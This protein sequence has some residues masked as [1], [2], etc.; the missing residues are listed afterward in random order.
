M[1]GACHTFS[2]LLAAAMAGR[3]DALGPAE[4]EA[5]A[6]HIDTCARCAANLA[7]APARAD[8]RLVEPVATVAPDEWERAWA[9]IAAAGAASRRRARVARVWRPLAIAAAAALAVGLWNTV[10][11]SEPHAW[12]LRLARGVEVDDLEVF[13]GGT[14][15]IIDAGGANGFSVIWV[16]DGSD[17]G[18]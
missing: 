16:M 11:P 12:Q 7:A 4:A 3:W 9:R 1:S 15:A 2:K 8:A 10:Q 5:L 17:E 14:A 18:A 13:G 6:R